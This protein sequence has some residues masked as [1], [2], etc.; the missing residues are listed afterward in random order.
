[1]VTLVKRFQRAWTA[2]NSPTSKKEFPLPLVFHYIGNGQYN[3]S[4][5]DY[6]AYAREGFSQN[7]VIYSAIKYKMDAI[8]QSPMRVYEGNPNKPELY[9]DMNHPLSKLAM[10]PNSFQSQVEFM[11]YCVMYLNL[12]G[13]CFVYITG[14]NE[15]QEPAMY[16]LR[17]DRVRIVPDKKNNSKTII[18]YAYYPDGMSAEHVVPILPENMMHIKF[19]NPLDDLE[20]QGYGLSP[21]SAGAHNVDTDNLMTYFLA[22]FFRN[23]GMQPGGVINLPYEADKEDIEKLRA[24]FT[25]QYGGA[26]NWGKPVIIDSSGTFNQM[27]STFADMVLDQID[28]RNIRRSTVVFGVPARLIGLDEANST[29]NN[30][31]EAKED[32]WQRTM[33]SELLL[34]E[35]EFRHKLRLTDD[36]VFIRY[37]L[38]NIPAFAEDINTQVMNYKELVSN[39]VPP[40]EAKRFVGMNIPDIEGGDIAYMPVGLVPV[41]HTLNPPEVEVIPGDNP[42]L[43]EPEDNSTTGSDTDISDIDTPEQEEDSKKSLSG[44]IKHKVRSWDFDTKQTIVN[45]QDSIA[46]SFEPAWEKQIVKIFKKQRDHILSLYSKYKTRSFKERKNIDL[47]TFENEVR[48]YLFTTSLA[49][50]SESIA[51]LITEVAIRTRTDW[52]QAIGL[53]IDESDFGTMFLSRE[54]IE[55]EAWF[56]GYTLRFAKD[57]NQTTHEGIHAVIRDGLAEGFGTDKIGN[58]LE[59]LFRQYMSGNTSRED[60]EFMTERMPAYRTEMIARTETHGAMSYS[61]HSFFKRVGATKKEWLATADTRTRESHLQAWQRYS[62][63][64]SIGAIDIDDPFVVGGYDMQHPGDKSAPLKEIINCRCSELPFYPEED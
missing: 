55:G 44:I 57:I 27:T 4:M 45:N 16:T 40:N 51:P 64:G 20:G 35:E 59:Q 37:D 8:A 50:V 63:G 1:M 12:H 60:W 3:W 10:R 28:L 18:G 2:F 25:E 48:N 39:F 22:N 30:I 38:S 26:E 36:N 54:S 13:N 6:Q 14:I 7:S 15:N 56:A 34:F 58:K 9:D 42:Q 24:Q 33:Y 49:D 19:P 47:A 32:F 62:E 5:I 41:S 31:S 46:E 23:N 52:G 17:P 43:P 29:Y 11:Q 61:N 21:L 53:G